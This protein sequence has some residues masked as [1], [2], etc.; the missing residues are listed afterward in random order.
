MNEQFFIQEVKARE[1]SLYRV[2]ISYLHR[3][4]DAADAVQEAL[5]ISWEKRHTLRNPDFFGTWLTRILINTCKKQLRGRKGEVPLAEELEAQGNP[6]PEDGIIIRDA[7]MALDLIY[8]IPLILYYLDG[9]PMKEV[10][11][12]MRL[13]LGTV[14]SRLSRGKKLLK[15][16]LMEKEVFVDEM[17]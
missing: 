3:D 9:Y 10:A 11:G 6:L 8:R 14:K 15:E 17:E 16:Q 4:Q 7:L 13:P 1:R 12:I 2:A 5:M